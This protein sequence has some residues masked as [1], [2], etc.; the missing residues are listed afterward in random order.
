MYTAEER[1][2]VSDRVVDWA[3]QDER[4]VAAAVI[5]SLARGGGDRWSD[6][7]LTFAVADGTEIADVL[8]DW[9]GRMRSEIAAVPLFDLPAGG[10]IYRVFLLPGCLQC[11]LS[12]AP[13][14]VFAPAGPEFRLLFGAAGP[15][16]ARTPRP[17]GDFFGYAVHHALRARFCIERDRLWQAEYWI[18]SLRAEILGL[19]CRRR[20]L[21][22]SHGRGFDQLP[23]AVLDPL[24][25]TLV[26]ALERPELLRALKN[27]VEALLR[28]EP[29]LSAPIEDRLRELIRA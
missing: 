15:L 16:Q 7:D 5:G 23:A 12:F 17:E 11:D 24:R 4:V 14:T 27:A 8:E 2:A 29:A 22:P 28:E 13:E 10:A 26:G 9:T 19:A 3:R 21:E 6:I 25:S 1:A 20:G 18:G